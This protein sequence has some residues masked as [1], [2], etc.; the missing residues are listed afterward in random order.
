MEKANEK[1]FVKEDGH[2]TKIEEPNCSPAKTDALP[3]VVRDSAD[4]AE[5]FIK[6]HIANHRP[7]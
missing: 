2:R 6:L 7:G 3:T 4:S 1:E 5:R